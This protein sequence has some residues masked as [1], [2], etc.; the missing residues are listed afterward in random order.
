MCVI[1]CY[2]HHYYSVLR[3]VR[4]QFRDKA[5]DDQDAA[6]E[7]ARAAASGMTDLMAMIGEEVEID[8][9]RVPHVSCWILQ[10]YR[11]V[12]AAAC[13]RACA[14]VRAFA[15]AH[16]QLCARAWGALVRARLCVRRCAYVCAS[17]GRCRMHARILQALRKPSSA[18]RI[19]PCCA[20]HDPPCKPCRALHGSCHTY[21]T[22]DAGPS[23]C[24]PRL[25]ALGDYSS[26]CAHERS[27][28]L[29]K[30]RRNG[31][32]IVAPR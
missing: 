23:R 29:A 15:C 27:P 2:Y 7:A 13:V 18:C 31:V 11:S 12:R 32:A 25:R 28:A 20:M 4:I 30:E 26:S 24:R 16:A 19:A 5:I 10:V 17:G 9:A 1:V 21:A 3:Q 22:G 8:T 6:A 14:R